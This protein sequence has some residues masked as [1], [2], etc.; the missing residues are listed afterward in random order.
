MTKQDSDWVARAAQTATS[1]VGAALAATIGGSDGSVGA[2]LAK[3]GLALAPGV[4]GAI[5]KL[6]IQAYS[7]RL[8]RKIDRWMNLVAIFMDRGSIDAAAAEIKDNIEEEW[9]QAGVVEG[10][11]T[12]LSDISSEALPFLARLTAY[13][14]GEKKVIDARAKR[15]CALLSACDA[16][17]LKA[18]QDI[19][20]FCKSVPWEHAALELHM[21]STKD[22]ELRRFHLTAIRHAA[23][24][25]DRE[26]GRVDANS[27]FFE[28]LHLLKQ[29]QFARDGMSGFLDSIAGPGVAIIDRHDL[30]FIDPFL[31]AAQQVGV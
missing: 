7:R 17:V 21:L 14:L 11:R 12:I 29:Y 26:V 16:Q 9:A 31:K 19:I 6:G 15:F 30:E 4:A 8:E 18:V 20:N 23:K 3:T 28:G 1:G 22:G 5:A 10:V 25:E 24:P 13:Y 27:C 2:T